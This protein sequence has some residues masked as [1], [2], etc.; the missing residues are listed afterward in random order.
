MDPV[1]GEQ[2]R[3]TDNLFAR[4]TFKTLK[5]RWGVRLDDLDWK[6]PP[7]VI[8]VNVMDD[9]QEMWKAWKPAGEPK[10]P[11][12]VEYQLVERRKLNGST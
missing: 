12:N 5:V 1:D 7:D 10:L 3:K 11:D 9:H 6:K 4:Q 2:P 8:F